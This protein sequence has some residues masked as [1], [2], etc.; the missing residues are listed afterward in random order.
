MFELVVEYRECLVFLL[1]YKNFKR[2]FLHD[3]KRADNNPMDSLAGKVWEYLTYLRHIP[4]IFCLRK[5]PNAH[6][7]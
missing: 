3:S 5:H 1:I 4:R 7:V 2:G 6:C